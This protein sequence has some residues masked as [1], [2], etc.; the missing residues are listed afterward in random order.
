MLYFVLY[1]WFTVV[2]SGME[3]T[4]QKML[5]KIRPKYHKYSI[6]QNLLLFLIYW[7]TWY[8]FVC[9]GFLIGSNS[10]FGL[11]CGIIVIVL[12]SSL[13]HV[14]S[15]I[16]IAFFLKKETMASL[17]FIGFFSGLTKICRF[18]NN[19]DE[20]EEES[21]YRKN[22][23]KDNCHYSPFITGFRDRSYDRHNQC[24]ERFTRVYVYI[25]VVIS[26][27]D[28]EYPKEK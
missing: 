20:C 5:V 7:S 16:S 6:L 24:L 15:L 23:S 22:D 28:N 25:L 12:F 9:A 27:D 11:V 8:T 19:N 21:I 3:L 18:T 1:I 10:T 4:M 14:L 13:A 26:N 17:F 2:T